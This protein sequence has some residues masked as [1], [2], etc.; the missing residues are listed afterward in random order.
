PAL[1]FADVTTPGRCPQEYSVTRTWTATD[2]CGNSSN[3]TQTIAVRDATAPTISALPGP[4]TV[5]GPAAPV[6]ATPTASDDCDA[7]PS[8]TFTDST[9]PGLCPQAYS[10]T[11]TWTATDHCGNASTASQ[12]IT[13]RDT[14][15]PSLNCSALIDLYLRP[16]PNPE[17]DCAS[18]V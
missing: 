4:S 10:V 12:T 17:P 9:T 15:P 18:V 14:T 2:A 7:E 11:R 16:N 13:V 3:A 8:L 6:F 5:E 1:T